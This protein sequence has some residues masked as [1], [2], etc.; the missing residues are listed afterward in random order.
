MHGQFITQ[1]QPAIT[2]RFDAGAEVFEEQ[3]TQLALTRT[4]PIGNWRNTQIF[5]E[6]THRCTV[7]E[8]T[9]AVR[10]SFSETVGAQRLQAATDQG[11]G[12]QG[13]GCNQRPSLPTRSRRG[14]MELGRHGFQNWK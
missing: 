1:K 13:E 3:P 6:G 4:Q 11:Q 7:P 9:P 14:F 2:A 8:A 12:Q 5:S 10:L